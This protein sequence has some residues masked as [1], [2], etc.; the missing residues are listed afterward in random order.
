M[1]SVKNPIE[2]FGFLNVI[3][4]PYSCLVIGLASK[5]SIIATNKTQGPL[6]RHFALC[7]LPAGP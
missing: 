7:G 5:G 2:Y 6:S 4:A 1:L 3:K